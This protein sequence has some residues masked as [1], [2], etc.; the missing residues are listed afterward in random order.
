[1]LDELTAAIEREHDH[2]H[3]VSAPSPE[4]DRSELVRRLLAAEHVDSAEV[5]LLD[6]DL[7]AWHLGIIA[8]GRKA[9]RTLRDLGTGLGCELLLDVHGDSVWAWLGRSRPTDARDLKRVFSRA[10]DVDVSLALGEPGVG[11]DGWSLTHHQA[12]ETRGVSVYRPQKMTWYAENRL[13]AAGLR[14]DTLAR[15]LRQRYVAPLRGEQDGGMALR[16]TLRAYIDAGCSA[17]SAVHAA[18]V[19]RHTIE[20]RVQKAERLIGRA[21]WMCLPELDVALRLE[22]LADGPA[23]RS[24]ARP[25][26]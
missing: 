6:Y 22:E 25:T 21:I 1:L 20:S 18:G 11:I 13:L 4:A 9:V 19:S 2:D 8:T 14:N 10:E 15:S 12:R 3:E 5:R 16:R 7:D 26:G 24:A 23:R 17:T